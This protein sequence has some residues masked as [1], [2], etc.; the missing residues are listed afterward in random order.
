[1]IDGD[2]VVAIILSIIT[3]IL[4]IFLLLQTRKRKYYL[5]KINNELYICKG[6]NIKICSNGSKLLI[7]NGA[8]LAHDIQIVKITLLKATIATKHKSYNIHRVKRKVIV[9]EL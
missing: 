7:V 9:E 8:I 4:S 6:I 3:I 5:D 1:M 2:I